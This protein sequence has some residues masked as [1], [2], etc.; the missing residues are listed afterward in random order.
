LVETAK[1]YLFD[2]GVANY[3][4]PE[5]GRISEGSDLFG[6]AFEHFLMNEV[7]AYLSYARKHATLSFWRT[8][9]GHE[10]DL[11]IGNLDVAIEFKSVKRVRNE[12]MRGMHALLDEH[13]LKRALIVCREEKP[14]TTEDG[15]EVTPWPVFCD[16]LWSGMLA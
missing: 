16:R 6:R 9:Q 7:R 8:S 12:D 2:I 15:I 11:I 13:R 1:F 4:N 14:R 5:A 3:L 10:V